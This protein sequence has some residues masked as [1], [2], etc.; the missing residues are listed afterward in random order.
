MKSV[1]P[2]KILFP[3]RGKIEKWEMISAAEVN[4]I[5]SQPLYEG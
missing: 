2:K 4:Q 3:N 1:F 5:E